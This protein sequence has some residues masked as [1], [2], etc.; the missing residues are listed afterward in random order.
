VTV[1]EGFA[2]IK[3]FSPSMQAAALQNIECS[4]AIDPTSLHYEI[5]FCG[6]RN[7]LEGISRHGNNVS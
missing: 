3:G 4:M 2:A 1:K 6:D 5:Y 7:V